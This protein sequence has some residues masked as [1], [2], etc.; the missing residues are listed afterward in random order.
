MIGIIIIII[1][2]V[3]TL[4]PKDVNL[5]FPVFVSGVSFL[6]LLLL[7]DSLLEMFRLLT[8]VYVKSLK[9]EAFFTAR[10]TQWENSEKGKIDISLPWCLCTFLCAN[11]EKR[12]KKKNWIIIFSI[13]QISG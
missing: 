8:Q 13:Y 4:I 2:I 9:A 1:V 10:I 3:Q 7:A 11:V 12:K 5:Q 6:P